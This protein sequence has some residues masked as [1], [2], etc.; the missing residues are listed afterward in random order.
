MPTRKSLE[1]ELLE[2]KLRAERAWERKKEDLRW[3]HE[4]FWP[5]VDAHA[6]S[7]LEVDVKKELESGD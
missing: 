5:V 7:E 3:K 4:V 2:A 6:T 1:R